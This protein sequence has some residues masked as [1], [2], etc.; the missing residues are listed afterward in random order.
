MTTTINVGGVPVAFKATGSTLRRYR[1][2]F[3]R[4]LFEDFG[5]IVNGE[6]SGEVMTLVQNFA[7][8]MAKQ[9]D[10]N[11]PEDVE[12]WLDS[13]ETFPFNEVAPAVIKLWQMSNITSVEVKKPQSR[14]QGK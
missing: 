2:K 13:F 6:I 12:E 10:D 7:Y 11:V 9:A 4:D 14:R 3:N 1:D 8:I 5:T